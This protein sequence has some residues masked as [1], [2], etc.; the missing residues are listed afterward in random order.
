MFHRTRVLQLATGILILAGAIFAQTPPTG[1][2]T[3]PSRGAEERAGAGRRVATRM[4]C[5]HARSR[6]ASRSK[7]G[8]RILEHFAP[9]F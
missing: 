3:A 2:A 5:G 4:A 6:C 1:G 9:M 7:S 8:P